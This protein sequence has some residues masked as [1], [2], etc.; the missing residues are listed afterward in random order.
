MSNFILPE[1]M[2][3]LSKKVRNLTKPTDYNC[4]DGAVVM[5]FFLDF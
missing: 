4:N 5:V 3:F 2:E 1:S